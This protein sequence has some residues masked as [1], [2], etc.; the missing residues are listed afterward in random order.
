MY[1]ILIVEDD[2]IIAEKI[3]NH[4][5]I[6]NH[7]VRI[8]TDFQHV[9]KDFAEFDP[10]LVLLDITLLQWLLLVSGNPQD[11]EKSDS[12]YFL[13]LRQHEYRHGNEH[14]RG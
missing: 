7:D 6:W 13:C 2:T 12:L 9:L 14:G 10:H 5:K 3:A 8:V 11:F 4:L 1:R